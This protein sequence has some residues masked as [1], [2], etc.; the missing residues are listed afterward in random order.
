MII[1]PIRQ[2]HTV[3]QKVSLCPTDRAENFLNVVAHRRTRAC[4]P[5]F[6][7]FGRVFLAELLQKFWF[8]G[9]QKR[10]QCR[11]YNNITP[12]S[13]AVT[14]R[15][16]VHRPISYRLLLIIAVSAQW[17]WT[18]LSSFAASN[19]YSVT[20]FNTSV[21]T[22]GCTYKAIGYVGGTCSVLTLRAQIWTVWRGVISLS[23]Q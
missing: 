8:F 23:D 3:S 7:R 13:L 19:F 21:N 17:S 2:F 4:L 1:L 14:G 5:N 10:V 12:D 6:V 16:I 20:C 11:L 15:P 9:T 18:N 22:T